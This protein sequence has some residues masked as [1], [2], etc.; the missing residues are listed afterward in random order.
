MLWFRYVEPVLVHILAA[1]VS[2]HRLVM[3]SIFMDSCL[4]KEMAISLCKNYCELQ[5]NFVS[6]SHHH[7]VSVSVHW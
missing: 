6:D 7:D 5:K 4:K 1:R 2:W 3:S